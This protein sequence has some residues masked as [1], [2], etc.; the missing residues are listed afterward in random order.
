MPNAIIIKNNAFQYVDF[1]RV[2]PKANEV[3]IKHTAIGVNYIDVYHRTGVY[4]LAAPHIPGIEAAGVVEEVG[5]DVIDFAPGER[6]IYGTSASG[7]AYATHNNI[8][9][10][11]VIKLPNDLPDE[12]V[13]TLF[14]KGMTV[15]ML[16]CRVY[17]VMP[18]NTI[19][20]HAA[21]GGVGTY[22]CQWAKF[23]GA[24]VIGTV[25]S[26][27]KAVWAENNGCDYVINT[28]SEDI[29]K[30]VMEITNGKG[31][32]VVYDSVGR[33]TFQQSIDC[34][35]PLGLLVSYG[36]S[37]GA[38]PPVD[39]SIFAKKSL[40]F[41]RP[42]V[43]NYKSERN[44]LLMTAMEIFEGMRQGVLKP[45]ISHKFA[46]KDAAEAHKALSLIHI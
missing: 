8:P 23:I 44:E 24:K 36:Q 9:A 28:T 41:T 2:A 12:D 18:E 21:A 3:R 29:V 5:S 32:P 11:D 45:R 33:A 35:A 43:F 42:T 20:I 15:H 25:S 37:S 34:L 31:V 14:M 4:P 7:G 26:P 22:M 46:L 39:L 27:E 1:P 38:V 40:F 17:F 10:K 19:L 6:V 13:L 16:L 30:R